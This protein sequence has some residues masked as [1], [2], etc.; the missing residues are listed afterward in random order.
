MLVSMAAKQRPVPPGRLGH[1]RDLIEAEVAADPVTAAL[2]GPLRAAIRAELATHHP[3]LTRTTAETADMLGL[4]EGTV[5]EMATDGR[6]RRVA[7]PQSPITLVSVLE[8]AGWPVQ[9]TSLVA[10]TSAVPADE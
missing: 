7:G 3:R 2:I 10:P 6:L 1:V 4:G 9:P 8:V 5:R